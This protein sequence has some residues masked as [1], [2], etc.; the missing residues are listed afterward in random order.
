ML[1]HS[2]MRENGT[3]VYIR[4]EKTQTDAQEMIQLRCKQ[5]VTQ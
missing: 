3:A 5:K 1:L 4:Q 2:N